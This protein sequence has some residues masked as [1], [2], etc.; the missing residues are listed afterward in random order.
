MSPFPL[1]FRGSWLST[2]LW[3]C[4]SS[5]GEEAEEWWPF[6]SLPSPGNILWPLC[7][8]SVSERTCPFHPKVLT[9]WVQVHQW[10]EWSQRAEGKIYQRPQ[11][12]LSLAPFLQH[13][14]QLGGWRK[15]AREVTACQ[16]CQKLATRHRCSSASCFP[17]SPTPWVKIGPLANLISHLNTLLLPSVLLLSEKQRIWNSPSRMA[18]PKFLRW[19]KGHPRGSRWF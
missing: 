12:M 11:E 6:L 10:C 4:S 9:S 8:S 3:Q 18:E 17:S 5:R 2:Q 16:I 13:R 15:G 7:T 19:V 14:V 1:S